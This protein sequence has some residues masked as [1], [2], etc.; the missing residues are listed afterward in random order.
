VEAANAQ[1]RTIQSQIQSSALE[2]LNKHVAETL[3]VFAQ[4][5]EEL[6][7]ESVERLQNTLAGGLNSVVQALGEHFRGERGTTERR[8]PAAD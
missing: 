3:R 7:R 2:S 1:L 8:W 6:E 5:M 4:S